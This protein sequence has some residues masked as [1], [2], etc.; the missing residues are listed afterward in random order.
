MIYLLT[1]QHVAQNGVFALH[2]YSFA[3]EGVGVE[4]ER[5]VWL[6]THM[7]HYRATYLVVKKRFLPI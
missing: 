5:E 2:R 4:G 1:S 7:I 6:M 3:E